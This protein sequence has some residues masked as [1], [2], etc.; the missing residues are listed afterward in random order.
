VSGIVS[1]KDASIARGYPKES[2]EQAAIDH[3]QRL[4]RVQAAQTQGGLQNPAARGILDQSADPSGGLKE[5]ALANDPTF[6][7]NPQDM[8]RGDG[9]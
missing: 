7:I 3:A 2:V 4:L 5:K 1:L 6:L 9:K 8:T